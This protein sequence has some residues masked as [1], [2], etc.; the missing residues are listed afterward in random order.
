MPSM[1][2]RDDFEV[3]CCTKG[4]GHHGLVPWRRRSRAGVDNEQCT[5]VFRLTSKH[6]DSNR[7]DQKNRRGPLVR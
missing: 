3:G 6:A 1:V 5:H 7:P 2:C 4:P